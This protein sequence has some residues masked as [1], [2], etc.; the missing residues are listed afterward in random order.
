MKQ[1]HNK[2]SRTFFADNGLE[3][4][5][6]TDVQYKIRSIGIYGTEVFKI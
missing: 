6:E 3:R 5:T 1:Q 4:T 2:P